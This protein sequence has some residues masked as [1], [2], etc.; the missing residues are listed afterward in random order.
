[1]PVSTQWDGNF[2]K[3]RSFALTLVGGLCEQAIVLAAA[4]GVAMSMLSAG[5]AGAHGGPDVTD[6]KIQRLRRL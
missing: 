3:S 5:A 6:K 4:A 1:M 2:A